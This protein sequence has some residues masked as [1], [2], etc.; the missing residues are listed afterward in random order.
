MWPVHAWAS[1]ARRAGGVTQAAAGVDA[2]EVLLRDGS[3]HGGRLLA[4][5]MVKGWEQASLP[6]KGA[7]GGQGW[8]RGHTGAGLPWGEGV[9]WGWCRGWQSR[10]CDCTS[11]W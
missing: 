1:S 6:S 8:V 11:R 7:G 4:V 9:L 5:H 3:Q 10:E 2:E